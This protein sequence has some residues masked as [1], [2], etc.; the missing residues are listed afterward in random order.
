MFARVA[1]FA[2]IQQML[3]NV[4]RPIVD[5]LI[6]CEEQLGGTVRWSL[7]RSRDLGSTRLL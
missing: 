3:F 4:E 1:L 5:Y 6:R 2:H 7:S